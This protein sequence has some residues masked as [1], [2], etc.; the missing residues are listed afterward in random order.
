[1]LRTLFTFLLLLLA[2]LLFLTSSLLVVRWLYPP[3]THVCKPVKI[4]LTTKVD[5]QD[6]V[7]RMLPPL[8]GSDRLWR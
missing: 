7:A 5:R 2:W 3:S 8:L 4:D 1:M 6:P